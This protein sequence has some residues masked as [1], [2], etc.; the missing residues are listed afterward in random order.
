M[1]G[2]DDAPA[3]D[4]ARV[5]NFAVGKNTGEKDEEN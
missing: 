5:A 2:K 1:L 4:E 3:I